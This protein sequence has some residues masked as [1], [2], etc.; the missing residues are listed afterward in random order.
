MIS[1]LFLVDI[2]Q[3]FPPARN[4]KTVADLFNTII[5]LLIIGIAIIF[6]FMLLYAGFSMMTSGGNPE[7]LEKSKKLF[8]SAIFGFIIVMIS[9]MAVKLIGKILNIDLPL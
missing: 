9:Y 4:F 2:A 6:L 7:N 1:S 5:P 8:Q 3:D